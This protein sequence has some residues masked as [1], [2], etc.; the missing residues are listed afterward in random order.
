MCVCACSLGIAFFSFAAELALD[1]LSC[2]IFL[3]A[4]KHCGTSFCIPISTNWWCHPHQG[5][6]YVNLFSTI[7]MFWTHENVGRLSWCSFYQ[8][9]WHCQIYT[10]QSLFQCGNIFPPGDFH[11]SYIS[12][13]VSST[14]NMITTRLMIAPI[15]P[16]LQEWEA[17]CN[18]YNQSG[19]M[20][21]AW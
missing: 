10:C 15:H 3:P 14:T 20:L 13:A 7:F 16:T 2:F 21:T 17:K 19:D 5:S 1:S 4:E 12:I 11:V 8:W 9:W 18:D 6:V